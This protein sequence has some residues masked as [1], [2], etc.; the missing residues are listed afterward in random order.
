MLIKQIRSMLKFEVKKGLHAIFRIQFIRKL[1]IKYYLFF[2]AKLR[3]KIC[4]FWES[5]SVHRVEFETRLHWWDSPTIIRYINRLVCERPLV[6]HNQGLIELLKADG[7]GKIP[8]TRGL[9]IGCGNG[10]KEF[11]LIRQGIVENFDLFEISEVAAES[12]RANAL[13]ENL[14][15][16][17][18]VYSSDYFAQV[19]KEYY[20]FINWDNSLHHMLDVFT[21][22]K[23]SYD[24]LRPGGCFF[25][26]EYVGKNHQQF[27]QAEIDAVNRFRNS[28]SE[29]I[30]MLD[31]HSIRREL[32]P[33]L[34]ITMLRADPS[35][36]AD[37]ENII[38]AVQQYF[39]EGILIPTGGVIYH[40]G[41]N[42]IIPNIPETSAILDEALRLD[43]ELTKSGLYQYAV[44]LGF[45]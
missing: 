23:L 8:Y 35:E 20:D 29:E 37:S 14:A 26:N 18:R 19:K 12:I 30:F 44:F 42:R 28:L 33:P 31:S 2:D 36:G 27:S 39:P 4:K 40:F 16:R 15:D 9:S 41:L 34:L 24:S 6:G 5:T 3:T 22:V 38:P 10:M 13:R 45:K 32:L 11:S 17:V 43:E 21:A 25:M 1:L 7:R